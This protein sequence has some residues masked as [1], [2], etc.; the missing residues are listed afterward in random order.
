L[1]LVRTTLFWNNLHQVSYKV[2]F[3]WGGV[4]FRGLSG[5]LEISIVTSHLPVV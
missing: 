3:S 2:Q 1:N 5:S 4:S